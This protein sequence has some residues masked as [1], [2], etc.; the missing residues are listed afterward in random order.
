MEGE[1]EKEAVFRKENRNS[2]FDILGCIPWR[3]CPLN[4]VFTQQ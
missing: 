2:H 3:F 4:L 1:F